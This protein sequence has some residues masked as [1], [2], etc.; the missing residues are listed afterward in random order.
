MVVKIAIIACLA[1]FNFEA[2]TSKIT[3]CPNLSISPIWI[4]LH[5]K[6]YKQQAFILVCPPT[7]IQLSPSSTS[8]SIKQ[9]QTLHIYTFFDNKCIKRNYKLCK[10]YH[11]IL[12]CKGMYNV[13]FSGQWFFYSQSRTEIIG[14]F[15]LQLLQ[16][17]PQINLHFAP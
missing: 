13:W 4:H 5:W 2:W 8:F 1:L 7:K 17:F 16:I 9:L 10:N 12:T 15:L 6:K 14:P 11:W 3:R